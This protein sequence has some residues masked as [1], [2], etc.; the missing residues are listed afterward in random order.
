MP[1]LAEYPVSELDPFAPEFFA[2]RYRYYDQLREA[3]PV[4]RLERYGVWA[5]ARYA[6]VR[7][8]LADPET[9]CSGGGVGLSNLH[10]EQHWRK[11]SILLEND[12]PDHTR[13]RRALMRVL[14][15]KNI[16]KL[17][18]LFESK[19]VELIE[20]VIALGT[21]DAVRDFARPFPLRVF[22]DAVGLVAEDREPL[23]AYGRM[24]FDGMGPQNDIYREVMADAEATVEWINAQCQRSALRPGGL[25]AQVYGA[26]DAGELTEAEGALVVRSF[27]SAGV[28]TTIHALASALYC[29][30]C[31]P[32]QWQ[33]LRADVSRAGHAFEE[34][35]RYEAPFQQFFRTTTRQTQ[36][37]DVRLGPEEKVL[38]MP[39]SANQDPRQLPD[40][41]RFDITRRP[42]GHLGFGHGIH[43]CVGQLIARLEGEVLLT[44]LA[45]RVERIELAG[46]PTWG[47]SN[48]LRGLAQLQVTVR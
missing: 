10:V 40:P 16:R 19:A 48:T 12:P 31:Y 24:V 42:V 3:G 30:A 44:E 32:E 47:H 23:V 4:V 6:E 43:S 22:P 9:Y 7:S 41:D 15:A 20:Q 46:E 34:L 18:E 39:G 28:D 26:V 35:L 38:V 2:D 5:C 14:T 25:G 27:L 17:R 21:F 8:V 11:P 37:A 45:R 13:V 36:L 1:T 29:F 33:L